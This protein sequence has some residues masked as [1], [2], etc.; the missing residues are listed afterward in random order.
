[1]LRIVIFDNRHRELLLI[2]INGFIY[3]LVFR[4]GLSIRLAG[5]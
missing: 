4:A 3:C 1:M 5:G 2:S